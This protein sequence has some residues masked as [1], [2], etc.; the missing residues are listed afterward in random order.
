MFSVCWQWCTRRLRALADLEVVEE[1]ADV[2]LQ[3]RP[4]A[5][6]LVEAESLPA[7]SPA[8]QQPLPQHLAT[9]GSGYQSDYG[10]QSIPQ[11]PQPAGGQYGQAGAG[12]YAGPGQI[13]GIDAGAQGAGYSNGGAVAGG[14][15]FAAVGGN[16][17]GAINVAPSSFTNQ[18]QTAEY[19]Q[20]GGSAFPQGAQHHSG[21][22][23]VNSLAPAGQKSTEVSAAGY[24]GGSETSQ[25]TQT[26]QTENEQE[27]EDEEEEDH[28]M[29][30]GGGGGSVG[31]AGGSTSGTGSST[32]TAYQGNA[33]DDDTPVPATKTSSTN[34]A[35]APNTGAGEDTASNDKGSE[36]DDTDDGTE[37]QTGE[38]ATDYDCNFYAAFKGGERRI[39]K[40]P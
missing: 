32:D 30:G 35:P 3:L 27:T 5:V 19:G 31:G 40:I 39:H 37:Q 15:D 26:S 24:Q 17:G 12:G 7:R 21:P 23:S 13:A 8:T 2:V 28:D 6:A 38:Q 1:E 29:V 14:S 34:Y 4:D 16:G 11:A 10:S 22:V 18:Q 20:Q 9:R 25:Q 33:G 36:Y